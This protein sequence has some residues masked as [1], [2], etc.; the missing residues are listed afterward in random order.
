MKNHLYE[1]LWDVETDSLSSLYRE[2]RVFISDREA[3]KYGKRRQTELNEGLSFEECAQDGY[4]FEFKGSSKI[5]EIDGFK[6][7]LSC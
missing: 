7:E 2:L 6:I 3:R 1:L 4:Y 5:R